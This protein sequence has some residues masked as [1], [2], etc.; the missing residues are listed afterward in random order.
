MMN[1]TTLLSNDISN[2]FNFQSNNNIFE[3]KEYEKENAELKNLRIQNSLSLR[4]KKINDYLLSQRKQ[5]I[6]KSQKNKEEDIDIDLE[7][8]AYNIPPLLVEEFDIYEDKLSV[9]HQFLTD[10]FTLLH[11]MKFVEYYVKQFIIY[12]LSRLTYDESPDIYDDKFQN[13]LKLVFHDIIKMINEFNN[14]PIIFG[15]TAILVNFMF[16]SEIL[17][18]EFRK[19]NIWKRLAEITE[20]KIPEIN[21]NIVTLLLNIYMSDNSFGKEYILSNYSRYIKQI[22]INY[23]KTFIDESKKDDI[24]L[25]IFTN[26]IKLIKSLIEKENNKNEKSFD[27]IM[28]MKYIY[29]YLTKIFIICVSWII[30]NREKPKKE[31]IFQFLSSLLI[32]FSIILTEMDVETYQ[33]QEFREE[34]FVSSFCSFLKFLILNNSK[35]I[36]SEILTNL[37]AELYNF[38]GIFFVYN[39]EKN[40][41]FC[42]NKIIIITEEY[43]KNIISM[44]IKIGSKIIFFLSNYAENLSRIKEIFVESNMI[45]YIK[46]FYNKNI[47]ENKLCYSIFCLI[48]NGF[49]FGDDNCKDIILNNFSNFLVERIKFLYDLFSQNENQNYIKFFVDKCKLLYLFIIFLKKNEK[50]KLQTFKSLIDYIKMSNIE[51]TLSNSQLIIKEGVDNESISL[52]LKEIENQTY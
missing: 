40:E 41:I 27:V 24:D 43:V 28:K 22:M 35:K 25:S 23:F 32:L 13:E 42:K 7:K 50:A 34:S 45:P 49:L 11:G 16:T 29:D 30:N 3:D 15:I 9:I 46:E 26:G 36:F 39:S 20:L 5:L 12:K 10:D 8:V 14:K 38:L 51:Q 37:L 33:M 19:I 18:K 31:S 6:I 48:E 44:D 2:T 21:D 52:L 47:S 17:V 1:S 4:K